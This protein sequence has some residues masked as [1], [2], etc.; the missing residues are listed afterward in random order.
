MVAELS[1][2]ETES[3]IPSS[4]RYLRLLGLRMA[5]LSHPVL[6][7]LAALSMLDI[8]LDRFL[9]V[10]ELLVASCNTGHVIVV[11]FAKPHLVLCQGRLLLTV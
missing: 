1:T 2:T 7:T 5:G 4:I 11:L 10:Q 9:I 3:V 8:L 6:V